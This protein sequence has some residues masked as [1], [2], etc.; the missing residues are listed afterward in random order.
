MS[1]KEIKIYENIMKANDSIAGQV[2]NLLSENDI[3]SVNFISSPGAGKTS[4]LENIIPQLKNDYNIAVIVGDLE[5]ARDAERLKKFDIET[6]Q[7]NTGSGCHLDANMI[8]NP[9]RDIN[10]NEIDLLFIENIGNL[11]CPTAFDL[12][13]NIKIGLFSVPEGDDKPIK[14][15]L[16][17]RNSNAVLLNKIDMMELSDFNKESFYNDIKKIN[18]QIPVFETSIKENKGLDEFITWL[19]QQIKNYIK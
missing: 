14:Y 19:R 18:P 6:I 13:E 4:L 11:V 1:T 7:I 8:Y 12:G 17:L 2:R 9:L 3:F 10:L 16:I 5:T 15:P